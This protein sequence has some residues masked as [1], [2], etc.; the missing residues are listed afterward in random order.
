M[1]T[2]YLKGIGVALVTP[3]CEDGS[4]D[5]EALNDHVKFQIDGNVGFMV[6]CGTTGESATLSIEEHSIVVRETANAAQGK[7]PI[8]AG[9]G[10]NNT[11]DVILR[12]RAVKEAGANA[13]VSVSPA[14]NKPSQRGIVE[15]YRALAAA[16]ECP[17]V[18][19][20]VPGRTSSNILPETLMSLAEIDNIV[21]VKEASSN[22]S[23]IMT[24][25][26]ERPQGFLVLSG[27][28]YLTLPL[29]AAGA[30]GVISVVAN[31]APG[32]MSS[33]V[34]AALREDYKE[35][36]ELHYRL[37]PLMKANFIETNPIP[38]KAALAMMGR[39]EAR[40]RLPLVPLDTAN[41]PSIR[42]AL[43]ESGILEPRVAG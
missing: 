10:G 4:V 23:Q 19:Y 30:D 16:V 14:Y 35:A 33:M 12:A 5:L 1:E 24:I 39:M 42:Q 11:A 32:L 13:I 17:I 8:L 29:I 2:N 27:D 38:V 6:P 21:G 7:V 28:D 25:I 37:L 22:I 26:K 36:R 3:F 34:S 15:H 18:V 43:V 9:A 41:E 20:N 31:E 40:Y